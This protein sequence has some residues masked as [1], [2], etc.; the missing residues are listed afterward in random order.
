MVV[1]MKKVSIIIPV[2]NV[3]KYITRCLNSVCAQTYNNIECILIDDCGT[4]E[5]M[6]VAEQ[7]VE[8]YQGCIT[9]KLLYHKNNKGQA[10]ARNTGIAA[11][12]GDFI[13][14]FDS[15][16]A[17]TNNCIETL[18]LLSEKY[19][20]ADFIQANT[21]T[22]NNEELMPYS[23]SITP[24]EYCHNKEELEQLILASLTMTVWNRLIKRSFILEHHLFFPDGILCEDMYWI[25]FLAKNVHS[26]VFTNQGTYLYYRNSN[27]DSNSMTWQN[28]YRH[29]VGQMVAARSFYSD[30]IQSK[31]ISKY[32]R[33]YFAGNLVA[34][35]GNLSILHSICLWIEFWQLICRVAWSFKYKT[36]FYRIIL[37]ITLM[38][39]FCFFAG[40]K[41]WMWR[42]KHYIVSKT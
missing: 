15:D 31:R 19:P 27:S 39:P 12:T 18:I 40:A 7:F 35:M 26:A 16:D 1:I 25:Y 3:E 4:D 6:R 42:I 34:T 9:F 37:F 11:A 17:I 23:F 21:V 14:F 41:G 8:S 38:P 30:I 22:D 10:T 24:P 33:Q 2:Y 32:Q 20:D 28:R 13:F 36:T 5:S 29:F